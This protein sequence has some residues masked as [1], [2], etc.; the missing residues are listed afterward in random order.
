MIPRIRA[1]FPRALQFLFKPARYKI[2]YGGR[3]SAKSWGIARALLL[4]GASKPLRIP[5][6]REIQKSI[7]DSVHKLLSDQ[8]ANLGLGSFYAVKDAEIVGRNGTEFTFHGLR[9]NIDNIK[10][11][12]GADICWVEEAQTVSKSSWAKLIP[13]IRKDGSEIW[14]SFNPELEE[15]ETYQRFVVKP[16]TGAVVHKL[17]WRDNP[18]FPQVL[19][20]EKDDLKFR[21]EAAYQNVYEGNCKSTVEGAI[22][23][24]ELAA[25]ES[26][27]RLTRV[28]YDRL[29]PVHTAW[30][31][32]WSDMV[33]IWMFQHIGF[34]LHLIDYLQSNQNTVAWYLAELG[35]KDYVY[36]T[37]WLPHDAQ[38]KTLGSGGKSIE[39]IMRT[40]GRKVR[41][42]P[43]LSLVDGINAA[44]T[45]FPNCWFDREKCADGLQALRHYHYEVDPDTGQFSRN[46]FHDEASHAADALRYMALST[47]AAKPAKKDDDDRYQRSGSGWM[48]A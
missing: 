8:I 38:A 47:Q 26:E 27:G 33:S 6:C 48:A 3:G 43:R 13:T 32:G 11:L 10:S 2:A 36:D 39:Q 15:D 12:E 1:K 46:P 19:K 41:I 21:D 5:C 40:A 7:A 44:R 28:P 18:W 35:R 22:Y 4:L 37:D 31:L 24:K 29:K 14:V 34:E 25:A 30:D 17:T 20:Q 45:M 23:A 9:H 16:P 42:V